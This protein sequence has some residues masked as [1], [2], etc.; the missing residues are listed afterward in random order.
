MA[1]TLVG[2]KRSLVDDFA[3]HKRVKWGGL[4]R[5]RVLFPDMD[6]EILKSVLETNDLDAAIE[7]LTSLRVSQKNADEWVTAFVSEMQ[8]SRGLAEARG[9]AARALASF[10]KF[11]EGRSAENT[12]RLEREN[13]LLK[14]AVAIQAQRLQTDKE[15]I[16]SLRKIND[17]QQDKLKQ[18][19][20]ANYS[21][22]IHL[23]QATTDS[24]LDSYH[25]VY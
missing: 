1:A 12:A 21:L 3:S 14:R 22:S 24:N 11:V 8:Q 25:D 16:A 7:K 4:G 15:T 17:D 20:L 10:E 19:Q 18:A 23:Q 13:L 9:R 2:R 6:D 5:L